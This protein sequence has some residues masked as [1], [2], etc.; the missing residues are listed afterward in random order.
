M[1]PHL[2]HHRSRSSAQNHKMVE[3]VT[4]RKSSVCF[5]KVQYK[6]K[7]DNVK[8][9]MVHIAFVLVGLPCNIRLTWKLA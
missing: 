9:I 7:L 5:E 6:K 1:V 2:A 3:P 4:Q 8:S